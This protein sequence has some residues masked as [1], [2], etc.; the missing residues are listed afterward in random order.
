[1]ARKKKK[2]RK[3]YNKNK[4][5]T[6][7][8]QFS[9]DLVFA[10]FS[11]I[12]DFSK[13]TKNIVFEKNDMLEIEEKVYKSF[14]EDVFANGNY[15]VIE[16]NYKLTT[17]R[18]IPTS[19]VL[20][21]K[22]CDKI[23]EIKEMDNTT[24]PIEINKHRNENPILYYNEELVDEL[25]IRYEQTNLHKAEELYLENIE[26]HPLSLMAKNRYAT[27]LIAK[28]RVPEIIDVYKTDDFSKIIPEREI[29][30]Y[31]E[32][33]VSLTC[34]SHYFLKIKD[35]KKAIELMKILKQFDK[36]EDG[37]YIGTNNVEYNLL[38]FRQNRILFIL[39]AIFNIII[40]ILMLP[41]Y[42]I[43][44]IYKLIKRIFTKK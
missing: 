24:A 26:N 23:M 14:E 15:T 11:D 9:D 12:G 40:A 31:A 6:N 18:I 4:N 42:I 21:D 13:Y 5:I 10:D 19:S 17:E 32:F 37:Y 1:M 25:A 41:F 2:R 43:K 22:L 36:R 34:L 29:F 8:N 44:W 7:K 30:N 16:G 38:L 27:F 3:K 33:Y 35:R 28:K 20:P 39:K